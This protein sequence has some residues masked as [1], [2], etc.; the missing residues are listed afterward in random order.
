LIVSKDGHNRRWAFRYTKLSSRKVTEHGLGPASLMTLAE[1]RDKAHDYRRAVARGEDPVETKREARRAQITF[2]E[3][4]R[5][6]IAVKQPGWRAKSTSDEMRLLLETHA[7]S[8]A[9]KTIS[10][11]TAN[12]IELAVKDLWSRAPVQGGRTLSAIRRVFD[13]AIAHGHCTTNPAEWRLMKHRFP[14]RNG[15]KHHTA[16]DYTK[17]PEFVRRLREEQRQN[18]AL[19]P[20][21]IEFLLLTAARSNEVTGMRWAEVDFEARVWVMPAARTKSGREHRV[22]LCDR[23]ME[24]LR[25]QREATGKNL[26]AEFVW[27]GR[28]GKTFINGKALYQFLT[29][30]MGE[31]VTI[32]GFRSAFR[33]YAGNE[34]HYDRVTCELALGHRAGDQVEIAYRRQDA[35]NKRR[36]LMESFCG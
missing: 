8:L 15:S 14:K 6:Y 1:A 34:T 7:R 3:V 5:A 27:P 25:H 32:H 36:A 9:A 10:T 18:E 29:K 17:V 35:L 31:D 23:A 11:I 12:D 16:M 33:D 22:P 4:A 2:A 26:P 21:V 20:W 28:S 24:L 30:T 13:Y 19:S